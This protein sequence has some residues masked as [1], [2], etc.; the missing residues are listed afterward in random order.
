MTALELAEQMD[1]Q[2]G[3]RNSSYRSF[4]WVGS[5]HF[6]ILFALKIVAFV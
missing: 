3:A 4:V 2:E 1:S 6:V 5:S